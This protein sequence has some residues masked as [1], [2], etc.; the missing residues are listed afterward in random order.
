M[1]CFRCAV[2]CHVFAVGRGVSVGASDS[3]S[4]GPYDNAA[5]DS[6][7]ATTLGPGARVVYE[8]RRSIS[9]FCSSAC[10]GLRLCSASR[11]NCDN[12]VSEA[13]TLAIL[14]L[15]VS[16]D[17]TLGD[18]EE[19]SRGAVTVDNTFDSGRDE[20]K[21]GERL[22]RSC[23][24]AFDASSSVMVPSRISLRNLTSSVTIVD[25]VTSGD[26]GG[27]SKFCTDSRRL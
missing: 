9:S 16:V 10:V 14:G 21:D 26:G 15:S 2:P 5:D 24:R 6:R 20:V 27:A 13:D 3:F 19:L 17:S 1:A 7:D 11:C 22:R 8:L 4:P 12:S 18:S 23:C 25:V